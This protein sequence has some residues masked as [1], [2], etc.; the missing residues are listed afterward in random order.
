MN[1]PEKTASYKAGAAFDPAASVFVS[2]NA[3]AG[4]TSLL[5]N[6][7]LRLLLHG[8]PPSKILCLTFTNAA[9]AEMSNR[10][11][12][13]LGVW[14][15]ADDATLAK[16]L[17][18]LA[19][20]PDAPQMARARSLFAN[21]LES[22]EGVRIQTIHGFCQSL[23][24][25]FPIEAGVSPHFTVMDGRTEQELLLEARL[26]LFN[27][28]QSED[29][30]LQE[31]IAV[32]AKMAGE[33][34]FHGLLAEIVQNKRRIRTL[35]SSKDAVD[36]A[37]DRVRA[38]LHVPAGSTLS[39]L[40][41]THFTYDEAAIA[42]WRLIVKALTRGEELKT[43]QGLTDWFAHKDKRKNFVDA[44]LNLFLTKEGKQR[45]RF[46]KKATITDT[47]L[48]DVIK[49]EQERA[50]RFS[51][52]AKA[53]H[54]ATHT[55]HMLHVAEAFL[56]LY[57][58]LKDAHA[59]MDYDDL[60]LTA[61]ALLQKPG[62]AP[63]V[64]Y[65]LDGGIDHILVD[66]AQDTSP[67]QWTIIDALTQEFFVG[68][69][70]ARMERS[71]FVVGDEKQSIFSFQGA[72]PTGLGRMQRYFAQRIH[73][74][75][76]PYHR[77]AL[78]HSYRST[79]EVLAAVDAV[80]SQDAAKDGLTFD[81]T[82]LTHTATRL[83]HP[84]L[85]EVWPLIRP[86]EE[87]GETVVSSTTMLARTLA[88]TIKKWIDGGV[89]LEAKG[90]PVTAGDIMILVRSRTSLVDKLVRALKRRG[91]PVAGHDRMALGENL[92]VQDLIALGQLLLLPEDDLTLA[93]VLKSPLCSI[94]EDELFTLAWNRGKQTLWSRLREL[95]DTHPGYKEAYKLLA[96]LQ[97]RADYI[98]P[99]ELYAHLLD[100]LGARK[101]I[102]GRMGEEYSDPL[103][104]F[105]GQ[106]LLYER[107]HTPSLQGFL[108]WLN[109][110]DSE[111]KR[112]MEQSKD[113]VRI[114]TVHGA[115]GLQAP[116][117]I[118]PD[119]IEIPKIREGLLWHEEEGRALPFWPVST[120][121]HESFCSSLREEQRNA[122]MAEYR[123]LLYVALTRAEDRL[124]VCGATSKEKINDVCWYQ[125]IR[126]G[127][128]PVATVF[129]FDGQE[130]LRLGSLPIRG[131][132][133]VGALS[134]TN[135]AT[136]SINNAP[137]LTSPLG[138]EG[139]SFLQRPA[140]IEPTPLQPLVPS[141]LAGDEPAAA[142]P[143][144]SNDVYQRGTL[145][146]QLLQY[147]PGVSIDERT[148]V[149]T[150]IAA[151]YKTTLP[152]NII[153]ECIAEVLAVMDNPEFAFLFGADAL[154][155][156]PVAGS[157][158]VEG[159]PVAVSGQIDRLT[160]GEKEVWIIDFKSNRTPPQTMRSIPPAYIRQMRLYQ[161][162]LARIY[163]EKTIRAAL[164]WTATAAITV[165]DEAILDEVPASSYI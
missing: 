101:R 77:I 103:D 29:P 74:A 133:G 102:T 145:I 149:A 38:L 17:S 81:N 98:S 62:I 73:D 64:L 117:V 84:G 92:A 66:E 39:S 150:R 72:D 49:A 34:A 1:K 95:S 144:L 42:H 60:I 140:P 157:V 143:L 138:G 94:S 35:F 114:M 159:K 109:A 2:A 56:A 165:L 9:A 87:E 83:E 25:R 33:G 7:V 19:I 126:G 116:I 50:W 107:S 27:R 142:S 89:M 52:A 128:A 113:M 156:V 164:L 11:L 100:T 21:V 122:M 55:A 118:V 44:Y 125:L 158:L 71:L 37:I 108:H 15:M 137:L 59:L 97:S 26:R 121:R 65:K 40:I 132:V 123:R 153:K 106:A 4:K 18:A 36:I 110:S 136:A 5:T 3:G 61:C 96:D 75:A 76:I 70:R 31:S 32:I 115:K 46:C 43:A 162:L 112:D 41:E 148:Q 69:G 120:A 135:I 86:V 68:E 154:A 127:L 147:L 85:V 28:A 124:I 47:D 24:R 13:E 78:T 14:V 30:A 161:L 80:F 53:L 51:D 151:S 130:G 57:T 45:A 88:D 54:I 129:D 93:S 139:L 111:I 163:P 146:H 8:A 20:T 67:E 104:E 155:E 82:I 63:W 119:T 131:R 141:R 152:D 22:P 10:V 160:I 12:K 23:L 16:S 90:R 91:V 134:E 6:R 58:K 48:L 79:P 99:Y 105:L